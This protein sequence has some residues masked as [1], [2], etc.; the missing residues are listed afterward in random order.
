MHTVYSLRQQAR[1]QI[2]LIQRGMQPQLNP[3]INRPY[4]TGTV[5]VYLTC[6]NSS[7]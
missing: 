1:F 7:V 3:P 5:Y 6:T 2:F 4:S